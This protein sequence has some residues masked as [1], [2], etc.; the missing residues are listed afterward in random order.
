MR[1]DL[2][3]IAACI[4]ISVDYSC[5]Y[6]VC[7]CINSSTYVCI[8]QSKYSENWLTRNSQC[9]PNHFSLAV[10]L[11]SDLHTCNVMIQKCIYIQCKFH[12]GLCLLENVGQSLHIKCHRT[13]EN[14]LEIY[15][16]TMCYINKKF[17]FVR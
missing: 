15:M 3:S 13:I 5:T 12:L 11:L 8:V 9:K 6:V 16:Q 10:F 14:L 1:N 2:W 17:Q 7:Y 4:S